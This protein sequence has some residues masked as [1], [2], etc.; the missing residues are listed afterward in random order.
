MLA[1]AILKAAIGVLT[2]ITL[3]VRLVLWLPLGLLDRLTAGL[4]SYGLEMLWQGLSLPILGL[5]RV[6]VTS[7]VARALVGLV[8]LPLALIPETFLLLLPPLGTPRYRIAKLLVSESWPYSWPYWRFLQFRE[9]PLDLRL[10][11]DFRAHLVRLGSISAERELVIERLSH[12]EM[13]DPP[14]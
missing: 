9:F 2:L 11:E 4:L 7:P 10:H 5:S 6:S 1:D 12:G 14:N 13:L 8:G 3:P